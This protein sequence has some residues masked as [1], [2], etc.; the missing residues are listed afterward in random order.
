MW[1]LCYAVVY[2]VLNMINT[3]NLKDY[4]NIP[5]F[6]K[7]SDQIAAVVLFIISCISSF[8]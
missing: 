6:G 3:K 8:L 2:I 7:S 5:N 1:S 4:C